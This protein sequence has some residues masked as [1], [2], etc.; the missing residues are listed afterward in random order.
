MK[1]DVAR[2]AFAFVLSRLDRVPSNTQLPHNIY[3]HLDLRKV[4]SFCLRRN[5]NTN[6]RYGI[7]KTHPLISTVT[8]QDSKCQAKYIA[9]SN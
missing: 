2:V 7:L 3:G 4:Q 8:W 1:R 5:Y 9:A 6:I